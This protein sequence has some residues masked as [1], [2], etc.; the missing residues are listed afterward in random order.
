VAD[1]TGSFS[2]SYEGNGSGLTNIDYY[3]LSNLPTTITPFQKNSILANNSIR[4]NFVSNVKAR[5]DAENVISSSAQ[6]TT[7]FDIRYGNETG[8]D[9]VSGS[10][11]IVSLLP[12]GVVSGSSQLP[13]GLIS[14]SS[15]L[16]EGIVSASN[17]IV[18]KLPDGVVSGSSQI[19][20]VVTDNYISASAASSGFG[21]T[22]VINYNELENIPSG[23]IS[24]SSQLPSNVISSS[25]QITALGYSTTDND[26]QT[27]SLV[28]Q[29]LSISSG[30]S[31]SLAGIAG[32]GGS[33][34]ASIWNTGS[35]DP[36]SYT[37]LM[38]Q[39]NL[40]VTGSV[41]IKGDFTV[42]GQSVFTQT[43]ASDA[44]NA[45]VVNGRLKVLEETI[46]SYIASA[47]IQ[48][49]NTQDTIDCGGFF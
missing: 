22:G 28:G 9:L 34:G 37:K 2:G 11:Q 19:T 20:S 8:D 12:N 17:Q 3:N 27:L 23:I 25:A 10:A 26:S 33:G 29:T 48:V 18:E 6:L 5:L 42:N 31:V 45:I 41:D 43:S 21:D 13:S 7:E 38:T 40:E 30:N 44:G 32:G 24:G 4:D 1:Y 36:E 39:N 49:G 15:Q 46:G 16:P 35:Q 47:S 14:G